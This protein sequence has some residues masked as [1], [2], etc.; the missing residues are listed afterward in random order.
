MVDQPDG[1]F[2]NLGFPAVAF[3]LE[4]GSPGLFEGVGDGDLLQVCAE[5]KQVED[6]VA[7]LVAGVV[8][9]L[10]SLAAGGRALVQP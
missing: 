9:R 3:G 1:D 5:G 6:G 10:D 7:E 2:A 4:S 8:V